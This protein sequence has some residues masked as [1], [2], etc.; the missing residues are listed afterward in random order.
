[1]TTTIIVTDPTFGPWVIPSRGQTMIV[2]H[3]AQNQNVKIDLVI[4]EPLFSNLLSKT[5]WSKENK[6]LT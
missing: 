5:R 6:S 4:A 3:Y 2:N 1:M